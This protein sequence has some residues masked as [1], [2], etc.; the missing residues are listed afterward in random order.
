MASILIF[1]FLIICL[2]SIR[3]VLDKNRENETVLETMN[4]NK[5]WDIKDEKLMAF[6]KDP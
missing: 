6:M 2:C 1:R 3:K 5:V 4:E